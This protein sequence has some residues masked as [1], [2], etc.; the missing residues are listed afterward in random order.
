M[1]Q[2]QAQ[3]LLRDGCHGLLQCCHGL[4]NLICDILHLLPRQL[5]VHTTR[6][7]MSEVLQPLQGICLQY[8]GQ[9]G[10]DSSKDSR[11]KRADPCLGRPVDN[12]FVRTG[13]RKTESPCPS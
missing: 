12:Q 9:A 3:V 13:M 4:D 2:D 11:T 7:M 10:S 8:E 1:A 5:G 6:K